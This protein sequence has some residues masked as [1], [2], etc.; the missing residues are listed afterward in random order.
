MLAVLEKDL[1]SEVR[2]RYA[3]SAVLLFAVTSLVSVSLALAGVRT[4]PEVQA[5]FLWILIFFPG[6]AGLP[7]AF[8]REEEKGTAGLLKL[9]TSPAMVFVGKFLFNL[10]LL[11]LVELVLV[12]LF[13][14]LMTPLDLNWPLFLLSVGLGSLGLS[15][16]GTLLAAIVARARTQNTLFAA[17][18]FPILLPVLIA[19]V[20]ATRISLSGEGAGTATDE[21]R[22][23]LSY[24]VV[25]F[26]GG[27]LLFDYV[28]TE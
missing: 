9:S 17:L 10:A 11:L 23:L 20:G 3:L 12:P 28:W 26:T 21:L 2:T 22:V 16:A 25:I 5:A 15:A 19:G 1:R 24:A 4:T 6:M 7:R 13:V 14:V 27:L 18:A 8:V